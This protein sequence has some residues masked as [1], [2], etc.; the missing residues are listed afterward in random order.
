[1]IDYE[2]IIT[3]VVG[4]KS[5]TEFIKLITKTP[6]PEKVYDEFVTNK[7]LPYMDILNL[8]D[9]S[10][11]LPEDFK[12]KFIEYHKNFKQKAKETSGNIVAK[13]DKFT[14]INKYTGLSKEET[15]R[16]FK[17]VIELFKKVVETLKQKRFDA[18]IYGD[19]Y[20]ESPRNPKAVAEY[21]HS[22]D[23][24]KIKL[25]NDY[26]KHAYGALIHELAHRIWYKLLENEDKKDWYNEFDA[27]KNSEY[28]GKYPGFP[29]QYAKE[30][31]EEYFAYVIEDYIVDN[32]K[33][34]ELI[35]LII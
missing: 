3:A 25:Y 15:F 35:D 32:K 24:I 9:E 19:I 11:D 18:I 16:S 6:N 7:H 17:A 34:S 23:T 5:I 29:N 8:I 20:L 2:K 33:Y 4:P 10:K 1:M 26:S 27:K 12:Q 28:K 14:I 13:I 22:T 21:Y 31:A 30:K